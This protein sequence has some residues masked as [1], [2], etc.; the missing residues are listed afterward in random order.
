MTKLDARMKLKQA[1]ELD[2]LWHWREFKHFR[3]MRLLP[4]EIRQQLQNPNT[5]AIVL[6]KPP[7]PVMKTSTPKQMDFFDLL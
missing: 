2:L 6:Y 1:S 5:T 3:A 4:F 7:V